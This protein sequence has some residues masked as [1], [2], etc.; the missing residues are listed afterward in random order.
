MWA[1]VLTIDGLKSSQIWF[2]KTL[3]KDEQQSNGKLSP[4]ILDLDVTDGGCLIC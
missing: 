1:K 3:C 2:A 4:R